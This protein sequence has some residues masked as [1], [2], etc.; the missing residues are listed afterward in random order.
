M[1]RTLLTVGLVLLFSSRAFAAGS[2]TGNQVVES[3]EITSADNLKIVLTAAGHKSN[4]VT[5]GKETQIMV[6]KGDNNFDH[7]LS[8]ALAAQA[9]NRKIYMWVDNDGCV[10]EY[11]VNY[12]RPT[13]IVIRNY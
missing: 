5:A 10:T 11:S 13:K 6:P 9:A 3:V 1:K 12:P 4:C 2:S 8:I 7:F